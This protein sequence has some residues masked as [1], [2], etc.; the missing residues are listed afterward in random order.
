MDTFFVC[1]CVDAQNRFA[2]A[3]WQSE[4]KPVRKTLGKSGVPNSYPFAEKL[5]FVP[6]SQFSV[7]ETAQ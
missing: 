3:L 5:R 2:D 1:W 4:P 7:N 6:R